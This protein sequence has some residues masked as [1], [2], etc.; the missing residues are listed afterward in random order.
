MLF[1]SYT[2]IFIH[3]N[4]VAHEILHEQFHWIYLQGAIK[5]L[6]VAVNNRLKFD[7]EIV[8]DLSCH[9]ICWAKCYRISITCTSNG[10]CL[11]SIAHVDLSIA[12][13]IQRTSP[14]FDMTAIV[15]RCSFSR[16]SALSKTN[17][18]QLTTLT[19]QFSRFV[20][21]VLFIYQFLFWGRAEDCVFLCFLQPCWFDFHLYIFNPA[22]KLQYFVCTVCLGWLH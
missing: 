10:K 3:R 12:G 15:S 16:V 13:G 7:I 21:L 11:M 19:F 9:P 6:L 18:C 8:H 20:I 17:H 1:N 14:S 2:H 5:L 22:V 4:P